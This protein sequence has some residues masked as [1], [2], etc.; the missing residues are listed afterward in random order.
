MGT[1]SKMELCSALNNLRA[2][3]LNDQ[4]LL[5]GQ[6]SEPFLAALIPPCIVFALAS[7]YV[8]VTYPL[9]WGLVI[10][11]YIASSATESF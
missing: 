11:V 2:V 6:L 10:N 9:L 3:L 5:S 1:S 8:E 7:M 4:Q